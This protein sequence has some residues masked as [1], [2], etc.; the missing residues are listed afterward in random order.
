M[1]LMRFWC[2]Y[3]GEF[4]AFEDR[5]A[6]G[7]FVG[8][9]EFVTDR[10]SAGDNRN[11][12]TEPVELFVQI[13]VGRVAF[14]GRRQGKDD[15]GRFAQFDAGDQFFDRKHRWAD[16]IHWRND[17][18][19]HMIYPAELLGVL[20]CHDVAHALDN[21]DEAAV[22]RGIGA[23]GAEVGVTD[24]EAG[25]AIHDVVFEI[26]DGCAY[27]PGIIGILLEYVQCQPQSGALADAGQLA[28]FLYRSFEQLGW[29]VFVHVAGWFACL[30]SDAGQSL[31]NYAF[32]LGKAIYLPNIFT[33]RLVFLPVTF[34]G[35]WHVD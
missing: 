31:Q 6:E 21:A 8:K 35:E 3:A 7:D 27:L 33:L 16:A 18:P 17:A 19:E 15:F 30:V 5:P 22:A 25:V 1:L 11:T 34:C 20:N 4:L 9:F 23:D 29:V 13:I 26:D 28:H 10:Y 24:I 32:S 2:L 14:H 12:D